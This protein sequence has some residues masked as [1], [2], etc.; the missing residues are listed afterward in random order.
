MAV[1]Q[2]LFKAARKW[3]RDDDVCVCVSARERVPIVLSF[4]SSPIIF[5]IGAFQTWKPPISSPYLARN[6][7]QLLLPR[8][9]DATGRPL[10]GCL[11]NERRLLGQLWTL[12]GG[13]PRNQRIKNL[14]YLIS[15][16]IFSVYP[17]KS[18]SESFRRWFVRFV[19]DN[20]DARSKGESFS[21]LLTYGEDVLEDYVDLK[22][23]YKFSM[24]F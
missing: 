15:F 12:Q 3:R 21:F 20:K 1:K 22:K 13:Y 24:L 17:I 2:V 14:N 5:R 11:S 8:P 6:T 19:Y 7:M 4:P 23:V 9:N 10:T 18:H 16:L